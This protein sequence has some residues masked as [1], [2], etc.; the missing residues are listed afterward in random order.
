MTT[1]NFGNL[2]AAA[3]QAIPY[4]EAGLA[5]GLSGNQILNG[6]KAAGSGARRIHVQAIVRNLRGQ[7]ESG[8]RVANIRRD[9]RPDPSRITVS[10]I[11]RM[12]NE[13]AFK[14]EITG[15]DIDGN[16]VKRGIMV[17][18]D[19]LLTRE[20]IE[21]RAKEAYNKDGAEYGV[22]ADTFTIVSAKRKGGS[23]SMDF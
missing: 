19:E 18:T 2:S 1:R 17:S 23:F 11:G 12:R 20:E 9:L 21:E 13:F 22:I 8:L 4:I 3:R 6:L 5:R 14:V 7:G 10:K 16:E 15:R